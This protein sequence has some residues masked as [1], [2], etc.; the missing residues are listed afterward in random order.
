[1]WPPQAAKLM[2]E[3][4]FLS[5]T[6]FKLLRK[7]KGNLINSYGF[8]KLIISFGGGHCDCLP[9]ASKNLGTPLRHWLAAPH[10]LTF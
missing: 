8:L 7:I 9:Q 5:S 3:F 2:K 10:T 1:M 4:D 6:N